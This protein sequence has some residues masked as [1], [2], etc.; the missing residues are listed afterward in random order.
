MPA[1]AA[2][3][4]LATLLAVPAAAQQARSTDDGGRIEPVSGF[5]G[6]MSMTM[7]AEV[8]QDMAI[9]EVIRF[10]PWQMLDEL[11]RDDLVFLMRA[12][13]AD[14]EA[15]EA[16]DPGIEGCAGGRLLTEDGEEVM[17][18]LGALLVANG[19]RPGEIRVSD[20]CR[21][22]QTYLALE[23]GMLGVEKDALDGLGVDRA[24]SLDAAPEGE[25]PDVDA[26]RD[27][28]LAWQGGEGD[29]P[30][31]MI[32]QFEEIEALTRFR[33]YEG[34]ML[35]ID[36]RRDG[37]VLGYL[38]LGS[39]IPDPL[40]FPP[41]VVAFAQAAREAFEAAQENPDGE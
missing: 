22:Q 13:P 3:F 27:A 19:L 41:D 16:A 1:R 23:R 26:L 11:F 35:I 6:E 18:Q 7:E 9:E 24:P 36:P 37:R 15:D 21:A 38:R 25:A 8:P 12:G 20:R 5:T 28:I 29:G 31:L 40:H 34:E 17:R 30:L 32:T 14:P 39:A 33:V 10:E 2:A 4:A